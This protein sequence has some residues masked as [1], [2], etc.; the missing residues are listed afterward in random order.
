MNYDSMYGVLKYC[1]TCDNP[2]GSY[3]CKCYRE[4]QIKLKKIKNRKMKITIELT[5][6]E[7]KGIKAYTKETEGTTAN[8]AAIV[9]YIQGIVSG[10]IHAPQEAVSDYISRYENQ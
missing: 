3:D 8:R 4:R 9:E 1:K 2:V 10:T 7:V 5:E 6:A